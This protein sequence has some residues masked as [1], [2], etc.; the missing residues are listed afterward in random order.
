MPDDIFVNLPQKAQD[1]GPPRTYHRARPIRARV[2]LI[3]RI[4]TRIVLGALFIGLGIAVYLAP[5]ENAVTGTVVLLLALLCGTMS[6]VAAA[7]VVWRSRRQGT[8]RGVAVCPGGL[9]CVL[10]DRVV[11][12][13]WDEIAS[14]W[15]GGRR[16][17][18]RGGIE[19]TMPDSLDDW[20]AV[21]DVLFQE[22]IQ[23]LAVC[24][25][26]V[27]LG[28]GTMEF[29]PVTVTRDAIAAGPRRVAWA[30]VGNVLVAGGRLIVVRAGERLPTL[31]IPLAEVPNPH[32]LLALVDRLRE[33][34]FG[35]IIIGPGAAEPP[36][37][38]ADSS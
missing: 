1:L 5:D 29:G 22:T 3:A 10:H 2:L 32:A 24:A 34:G 11:T 13:P 16:F 17:R 6:L 7:R 30:D 38:Q 21:A 4:A 36:E 25:S 26:A 23:R 27:I 8:V 20:P 37:E 28:G 35:S 12:A 19:V 31:M 18:T 33:G 15:D 9:I 14:I